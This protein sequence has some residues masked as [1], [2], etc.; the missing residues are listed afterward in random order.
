MGLKS[1]R[2]DEEFKQSLVASFYNNGKI[3]SDLCKEYGVSKS[4]LSK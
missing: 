2:Y 4:A 3:I 1:T